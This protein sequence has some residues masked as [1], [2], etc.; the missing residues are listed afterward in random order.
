MNRAD[1]DFIKF[2]ELMVNRCDPEGETYATAKKNFWIT[3]GGPSVSR[4]HTEMVR[5][6]LAVCIKSHKCEPLFT[7]QGRWCPWPM[8][9]ARRSFIFRLAVTLSEP[10]APHIGAYI[11]HAP[12]MPRLNICRLPRCTCRHS[13]LHRPVP[14]LSR[15]NSNAMC[16][17]PHNSRIRSRGTIRIRSALAPDAG[18]LFGMPP[19]W[20][21]RL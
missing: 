3:A 2:M 7:L 14:S 19:P 18:Y 6:F 10:G 4:R 9:V 21:L 8:D 5:C 16:L 13:P 20:R 12:T 11:F 1:P 17:L 15:K